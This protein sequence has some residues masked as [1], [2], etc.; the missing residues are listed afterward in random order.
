[1]LSKPAKQSGGKKTKQNKKTHWFQ[2]DYYS[3]IFP[4][5]IWLLLVLGHHL[6]LSAVHSEADSW[7]Q[8]SGFQ[9]SKLRER[10]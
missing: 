4:V 6:F 9:L 1:M 7:G 10:W 2:P 5:V 3:Q 8:E